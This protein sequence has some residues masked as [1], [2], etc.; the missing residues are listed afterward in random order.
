MDMKLSHSQRLEE[1]N[2]ESDEE[3]ANDDEFLRELR[4]FSDQDEI[5]SFNAWLAFM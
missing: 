1:S 3:A 5:V 2:D 4:E